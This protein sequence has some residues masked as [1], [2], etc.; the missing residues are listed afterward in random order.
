VIDH[1]L[2]IA[3]QLNINL[4][5]EGAGFNRLINRQCRVFWVEFLIAS[6]SDKLSAVK[7]LF[8]FIVIL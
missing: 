6:M 7:G 1:W 4:N 3:A 2:L 5:K 8:S